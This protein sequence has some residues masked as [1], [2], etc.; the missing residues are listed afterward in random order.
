MI[1]MTSNQAD[2]LTAFMLI[3]VIAAAY[4]VWFVWWW[5]RG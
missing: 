3:Y 2:M 1:A 4:L 5:D